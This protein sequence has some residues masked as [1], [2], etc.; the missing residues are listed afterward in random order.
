MGFSPISS[1]R[2]VD[3]G[4]AYVLYIYPFISDLLH[5]KGIIES[6]RG[7]RGLSFIKA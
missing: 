4:I 5:E 6:K 7:L 1:S 2:S 3:L